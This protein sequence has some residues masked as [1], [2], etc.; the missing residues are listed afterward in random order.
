MSAKRLGRDSEKALEMSCRLITATRMSRD[1]KIEKFR[2]LVKRMERALGEENAVTLR[3]LN[4]LGGN[5]EDKE[6]YEEAIKV[7]ERYLA[8]RMKAIG[9]DHTDTLESLNNLGTIYRNLENCEKAIEY[10][11][12]ALKGKEKTLGK[13][14]PNTPG[15][16]MHIALV[17]GVLNDYE[18]AEELFERAL[19][20]W[21]AQ[22]GKDHKDT[23]MCSEIF[24]I[25]LEASGNCERLAEL[26]SSYP[27]LAFE[28]VD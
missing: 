11:E 25:C 7:D 23:K 19:E 22:V 17:Y 18:K 1:E 20:G 26:I 12:R 16:V 10:Y 2:D 27:G 24:K 14:H 28:E 21:E 15:T 8:G 4:T 13:N 6:E 9:E 5:L 3:A